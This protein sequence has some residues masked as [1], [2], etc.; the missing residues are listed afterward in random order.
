MIWCWWR[1]WAVSCAVHNDYVSDA[2]IVSENIERT[3]QSTLSKVPPSLYNRNKRPF[4][5]F[6]IVRASLESKNR[7]DETGWNW[8][9]VTY[10]RARRVPQWQRKLTSISSK[11][12]MLLSTNVKNMSNEWLADKVLLDDQKSKSLASDTSTGIDR[13]AQ[14]VMKPWEG[15]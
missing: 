5:A 4:K 7:R 2:K 3:H 8:T 13:K 12:A 6:V 10:G 14:S 15:R 9:Y 1:S 11:S